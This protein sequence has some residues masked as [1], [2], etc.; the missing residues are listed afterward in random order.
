MTLTTG[1]LKE[2]T[3]LDKILKLVNKID[4]HPRMLW[5]YIWSEVD[6]FI[7][8]NSYYVTL[9]PRESIFEALIEEIAAG[10]SFG[11]EGGS[12]ALYDDVRDWLLNAGLI[13]EIEGESDGDEYA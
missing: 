12:E 9:V 11:L 1:Q 7:V 10:M 5:I 3:K 8:N 6:D 2:L 4:L 13:K